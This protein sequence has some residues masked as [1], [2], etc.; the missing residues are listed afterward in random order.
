MGVGE[1]LGEFDVDEKGV[2]EPF[3]ELVGSLMWPATMTRPDI[4][5]KCS[6]CDSEVL[7]PPEA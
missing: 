7:C 6:A 1:R 5:N 2:R 4:P 3:R